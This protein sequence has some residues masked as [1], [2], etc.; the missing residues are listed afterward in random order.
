MSDEPTPGGEPTPEALLEEMAR[1]LAAAPV[2]D[3][4]LQTMGTFADLAGV[5]LGYGPEREAHRD[6]PQ[7]R[8]AIEALRALIAVVDAELG[9]AQARP[10]REPL[11][12]LQLLYARE[13]EAQNAREAAGA[14]A[15]AAE[16]DLWTPGGEGGDARLWT[17][18]D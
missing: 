8:L 11:A 6:L 14:E 16:S 13:L 12:Q 17:P 10:F 15:P 18:G 5:R 3:I 1:R 4:L 2:R 9:A 7:A